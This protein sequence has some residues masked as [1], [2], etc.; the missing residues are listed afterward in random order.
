MTAAVL[1]RPQPLALPLA[2][3]R[4]GAI[5]VLL[6]TAVLLLV[7]YPLVMVIAAAFAPAHLDSQPRR[8]ADFLTP[9]LLS[10]STNTLSLG[11]TVSLFSVIIGAAFALLAVQSPRDRW[12][13]LMMSVPFLTP[14][15]LA[16]LAW[17]LAV[18]A[19]GYLGRFG[20]FGEALERFIF[21]FGVWLC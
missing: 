8:L 17:S 20:L 5:G 7:L 3:W 1:D 10:A 21:S 19:R 13:D 14:P 12:I 18:G 2:R 9:R 15:F 6:W 16:S 4:A 11:V